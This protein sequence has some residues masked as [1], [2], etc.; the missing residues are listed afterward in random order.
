M[1][2]VRHVT[3]LASIKVH[4]MH[5]LFNFKMVDWAPDADHVNEINAT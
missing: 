3:L 2:L 1:N 5:H 4:L